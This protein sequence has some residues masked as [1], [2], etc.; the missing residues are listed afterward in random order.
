MLSTS[1]LVHQFED[2]FARLWRDLSA[3]MPRH[4]RR[5]AVAGIVPLACLVIGAG[6]SGASI[7]TSPTAEQPAALPCEQQTWPYLDKGCL[8]GAAE[9]VSAPARNVRVISLDRDAPTTVYVVPV[10]LPTKVKPAHAKPQK[11]DAQA[12]REVTVRDGRRG[13]AERRVFTVPGD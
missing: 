12:A 9:P 8:R 2:Q 3:R 6:F 11:R 5:A 13:R 4:W 1:Q 7:G 10:P